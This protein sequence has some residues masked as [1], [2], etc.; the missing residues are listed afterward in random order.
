MENEK[1]TN[2]IAKDV[3][4]IEEGEYVGYI[5]SCEFSDNLKMLD[6]FIVVD[7]E[8][9]QEKFLP[10]KNIKIIGKNAIFIENLSKIELNLINYANYPIGKSVFDNKGNFLGKVKNILLNNLKPSKILTDFCQLPISLVCSIGKDY[11]FIGKNKKRKYKS[12]SINSELP[13]VEILSNQIDESDNFKI[14]QNTQ[15]FTLPVKVTLAPSSLL[16]KKATVDIFGFNNE[17]I[18]K[19]GQVITQNKI[20][21]AKK[22]GK[23][24]LL[25]INSK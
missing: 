14:L 2:F 21:K 12:F 23:L 18:I 9:E 24:N 20:D 7:E 4:S 11:V 3:I 10:A 1:I 15:N 8:S 22:H 19:E 17:L 25:I 5:L 16:N 13:K 6:G